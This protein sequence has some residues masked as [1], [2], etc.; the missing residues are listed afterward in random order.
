M[1]NQPSLMKASESITMFCRLMLNNKTDLPI[2]SSEMGLLILLTESKEAVTP[3]MAANFFRVSKPMIANMVRTLSAKGLITKSP[4]LEDGRSYYLSLTADGEKLVADAID[5]YTALIENLQ[6][7][8]GRDDFKSL[9]HL[10]TKA[11]LI[12]GGNSWEQ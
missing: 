11:N 4:S 9:I 12:L 1:K 7:K 6:T 8:M 10:L 2:R 5:D 3:L